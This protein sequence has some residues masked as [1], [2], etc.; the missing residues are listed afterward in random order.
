MER[1]FV[2]STLVA[3]FFFALFLSLAFKN[4]TNTNE[5]L[6]LILMW[7]LL[8]I[9]QSTSASADHFNL[10]RNWCGR[11]CHSFHKYGNNPLQT[12]LWLKFHSWWLDT[13]DIY[14]SARKRESQTFKTDESHWW[15]MKL[16]R[17]FRTVK[18]G[19]CGVH[20]Q[21]KDRASG[22]GMRFPSHSQ[23]L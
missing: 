18:G 1:Y 3:F 13:S 19:T 23:E 8:H 4:N 16:M 12:L 21:W 14:R 9:V 22:E 6:H 17:C 15:A 20:R 10:H 5:V 2:V 7:P 11:Y